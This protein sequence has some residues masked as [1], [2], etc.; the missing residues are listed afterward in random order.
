MTKRN[1]FQNKFFMTITTLLLIAIGLTGQN[2]KH[3]SPIASSQKIVFS[4]V[5]YDSAISGE[6]YGE[7][8]ELYN[9]QYTT[10][11]IGGWSIEDNAASFVIPSGTSIG[12]RGYLIIADNASYFSSLYGC[13]PNVIRNSLKL[14][15][16]G[17]YL[18]LRNSSHMIMDQV[19]WKSGGT[20]ISGWG[21]SSQ[22][23]ANE[24]KSIIRSNPDTDTD[25]YTDWSSNRS[26]EPTCGSG[27]EIT[28]PTVITNSIT[29]I[30]QTSA[31]CGGN[32]TSDGGA[33][34][35][36]RGVCWSTET[37]PTINNAITTNG[38]GIGSFT[39]NIT[40][41]SANTPYYVRA[42]ATNS[43]GTSYGDVESFITGS[44]G[45]LPET[46]PPFG[47]F[48]TPLDGSFVAGSIAVTGWALDDSGLKS[49]KIYLTQG[50]ELTYIGD[51]LFV[52]GARPDVALAYPEY[53]S[54]TKAGWGY[55]MLTN[56]LPGGGNGVFVFSAIATDLVG[57]TTTLGT[58][59]ITV[60][61]AHA[62]KPF[63][64]IDTPTQGGIAS[65]NSFVNWGWALTP[66]PNGIAT[67]GATIDV[68][69]D[70][71]NLGHPVYNIFRTDIASLFPGYVNSNGA[72][73]YFYLNT[74]GYAN[75][76][77]TIQWTAT[78]S[79]G[80]TDGIGSRYFT[81]QNANSDTT[82]MQEKPITYAKP[83]N[84]DLKQIPETDSL[85]PLHIRQGYNNETSLHP[86]QPGNNGIHHIYVE[87]MERL[88][89]NLGDRFLGAC[90]YMKQGDQFVP[91][92]IGSTFDPNKGVFY[93]QLGP[94]F[95][96]CYELIFI[97]NQL[98]VSMKKT[99]TITI[100]PKQY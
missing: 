18:I 54:N 20:Y 4:E 44:G 73:G 71:I 77:H 5:L 47:S 89:I 31:V 2:T 3:I 33:T 82:N 68:W 25:R 1:F 55:M 13:T 36:T 80:N 56:F 92:P 62:V 59:T 52:E 48:D 72:V 6:S 86:L 99:I 84:I 70:G 9:P 49:V 42:Y 11:N 94:G 97:E 26:P 29:S 17:D 38:T 66:Q 50:N 14:S 88:E 95:S 23:Y 16:T 91:L 27:E 90:G 98:P 37:N 15:N 69:V 75:G 93:W 87:E 43:M 39:S 24:N 67:N 60:D 7:W 12:S 78:D 53:P 34:V 96:G 100:L 64:A 41:L 63:G 65:G 8:I 35:T 19:A 32:V 30:T 85:E 76:V 51:A 83:S 46:N 57:K 22:P 79:A 21:S 45:G 58:K 28:P 61:N 74:T 81:I 10:V 40:G